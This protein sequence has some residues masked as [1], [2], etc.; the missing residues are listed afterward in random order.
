[1]NLCVIPARG[2]S[3]RIPR[4]NIRLFDGKPMLAWPIKA[5]I[6]SGCFDRIIV[7]T[8]DDEIAEIAKSYGAEI[9]FKRPAQ[10]AT[11]TAGTTQVVAHAV[12][13][14]REEEGILYENVCCL[15]A[16]AAFSRAEDIKEGLRMLTKRKSDGFIFTAT[17]Y[18]SPIQR[19]LK[20]D[21][22]TGYTRM[23]EPN[24]FQK[25][26]QDLEE[27]Y[28]DAGQ[29]YWG[30]TK[31]WLQ[32]RN[33]FEDSQMILLPRWRVQDIDTADDW[34]RAIMMKKVLNE[35]A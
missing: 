21:N 23:R 1:M 33:L 3:K 29:F 27:C 13:W 10:L 8:D 2:G 35:K 16:T 20:L 17:T 5:A 12:K 9:P 18:A 26:S 15:Y 32:E 28:H 19:A 24:N 7:S 25:R 30:S 31:A 4:K 6:D 11:D 22:E 14:H 34:E